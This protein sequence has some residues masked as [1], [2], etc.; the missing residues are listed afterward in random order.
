M[1]NS[2]THLWAEVGRKGERGMRGRKVLEEC[3]CR[4][5]RTMGV[6]PCSHSA[7]DGSKIAI[8]FFLFL[9]FTNSIEI[10]KPL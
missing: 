5:A 6:G 8:F 7:M 9:I 2:V 3:L 1:T 4:F 10:K